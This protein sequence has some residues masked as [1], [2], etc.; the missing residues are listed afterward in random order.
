MAVKTDI[1]VIIGGKPLTLSGMESEEYLQK[2]ASYINAKTAELRKSESYKRQTVDMQGVLLAL[3][4]AD[5]LFKAK[6]DIT[7]LEEE[8]ESKEKDLYNIKHELIS[9]QIKLETS[10]KKVKVLD[11]QLKD[12]NKKIMRLEAGLRD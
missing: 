4:I 2:V 5:D 11:E 12:A 10:E 7:N 8:I 6:N 1:E 9:S 3:N